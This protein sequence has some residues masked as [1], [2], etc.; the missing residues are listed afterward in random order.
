MEAKKMKT[1]HKTNGSCGTLVH[2]LSI[3]HNNKDDAPFLIPQKSQ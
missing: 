2:A 3:R 1:L